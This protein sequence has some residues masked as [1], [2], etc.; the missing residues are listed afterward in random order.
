VAAAGGRFE[1]DDGGDVPDVLQVTYEYPG[2]VVSYEAC[3]LANHGMGGRTPGRDYYRAISTD[4][5]PN[6]LAFY[7]T[8]GALFADRLG[9]EIYPEL[10]PGVTVHR[11]PPQEITPDLFRMESSSGAT[12]D[13]TF[14]HC[15]NFI[16]CVR[17]R[18]RPVADVQLGHR[19]TTAV[20]L[21]NIAYRTG[22]K[23]TWDAGKE[24]IVGDPGASQLLSRTPRDPWD[25][26]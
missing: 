22:R 19:S 13:S 4:D 6:G 25:V 18:Q 20:H 26:I 1:L 2:F 7:G 9:F 24:D 12:G 21:G 10:K 5:R 11:R 16:D 17:T 14:A 3:A 8:S 15:A 23:L